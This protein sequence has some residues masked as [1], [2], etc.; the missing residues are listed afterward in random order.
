MI[1]SAGYRVQGFHAV[2]SDMCHDTIGNPAAD[3]IKSLD[4]ASHAVRL[5]LSDA[6]EVAEPSPGAVI[7]SQ[8]DDRFTVG[9]FTISSKRLAMGHRMCV[10][11][12]ATGILVAHRL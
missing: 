4:L 5:A 11:T 7:S 1:D 8:L 10:C 12:L 9:S 3:V 2:L 6:S